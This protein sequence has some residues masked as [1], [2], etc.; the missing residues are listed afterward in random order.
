MSSLFAEATSVLVWSI[1]LIVYANHPIAFLIGYNE[2]VWSKGLRSSVRLVWSELNTEQKKSAV[3]LGMFHNPLE[4]CLMRNRSFFWDV[5]DFHVNTT[6]IDS[7]LSNILLVRRTTNYCNDLR[8]IGE[9][10]NFVLYNV[11]C[12]ESSNSSVVK[13]QHYYQEAH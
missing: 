2:S 8:E 6:M 12:R 13:L 10:G 5:R 3:L 1:T 9:N 11:W 4:D 7:F